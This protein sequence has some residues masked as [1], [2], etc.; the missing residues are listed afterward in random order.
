LG[1]LALSTAPLTPEADVALHYNPVRRHRTLQEIPAM[2][3]SWSRFTLMDGLILIA[4][5]A[6]GMSLETYLMTRDSIYL[7]FD[8]RVVWAMSS[9]L[10]SG[11][12]TGP[13]ILAVQRLRGR[14]SALSLGEWLWLSPLSFYLP[15]YAFILLGGNGIGLICAWAPIQCLFSLAAS[16][17]LVTGVLGLRPNAACRWTDFVGCSVCSAVGPALVFQINEAMNQ[18]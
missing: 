12:I 15:M 13:L 10:Y 14:R 16:C 9:V 4:A 5:F 6:L 2:N 8:P 18:L 11:V 3:A 7:R 1:S 17:W